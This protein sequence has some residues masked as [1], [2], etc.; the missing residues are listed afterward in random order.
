LRTKTMQKLAEAF[1]EQKRAI[2]KVQGIV[3]LLRP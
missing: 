2:I 3:R 1:D